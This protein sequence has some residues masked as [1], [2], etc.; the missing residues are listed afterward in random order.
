MTGSQSVY[1]AVQSYRVNMEAEAKILPISGETWW[2][3]VY[4][5]ADLICRDKI[6][7]MLTDPD[8]MCIIF[9]NFLPPPKKKNSSF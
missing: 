7:R 8:Q 4:F 9:Y 1:D 6:M 2:G 5:V 3:E